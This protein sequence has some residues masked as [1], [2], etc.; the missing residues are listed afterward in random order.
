MIYLA[1]GSNLKSRDGN[2]IF[3]IQKAYA[4]LKN[5][6]LIIYKKSSFFRSKAYPNPK[7]PEF[8]NSVVSC[9]GNLSPIKLLHII[10]KIEKKFGRIRTIKNSPRT[11]DIDIVDFNSLKLNIKNKSNELTI[12][13]PNLENRLFVLLPLLEISPLWKNPKTCRSINYLVSRLS[14]IKDNKITKL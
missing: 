3:L 11:L 6:G 1:F 12:P 2:S 7:D 4:E 8:L 5:Y 13:H 14:R 10:L 9:K